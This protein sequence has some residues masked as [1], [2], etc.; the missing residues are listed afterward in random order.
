MRCGFLHLLFRIAIQCRTL[1]LPVA[2]YRWRQVKEL[3]GVHFGWTHPT[4]SIFCQS[5]SSTSE[6]HCWDLLLLSFVC[7]W[8][9]NMTPV[10]ES[11][12]N[13]KFLKFDFCLMVPSKSCFY[14][15]ILMHIGVPQSR[16]GKHFNT[17][18]LNW[19]GQTFTTITKGC[20]YILLRKCRYL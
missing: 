9:V 5:W 17:S 4:S 14:H 18:F 2:K 13:S 8:S 11:R 19:P 7:K 10:S 16:K 3:G 12:K 15:K 1:P 6:W 20:E